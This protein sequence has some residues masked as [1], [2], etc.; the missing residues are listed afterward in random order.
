LAT[1][2]QPWHINFAGLGASSPTEASQGSPVKGM[3]SAGR[4]LETAPLQV[5]E[6]LHEDQAI[7]LLHMC[8]CGGSLGLAH[9]CSLV[10]GSVS[11][12]PQGSRLVDSVGLPVPFL[13]PLGPSILPPTLP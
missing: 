11:E 6:D 5:L 9:V 4:Q 8:E 13:S 12:R 1:P 7:H 2:P 3:G 10:G